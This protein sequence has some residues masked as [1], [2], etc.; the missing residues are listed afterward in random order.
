[1]PI[2]F[3][4]FG[5]KILIFTGEIKRFVTHIMENPPIGNLFAL[6]FGWAQDQ[7][8]QKCQYLTQNDQKANFWPNF[9]VVEP[10][11]LI[12]SYI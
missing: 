9:A 11:I 12:L 4:V 1:M 2:F 3:V 8:G 6:F 7:M 10:K 5:Q